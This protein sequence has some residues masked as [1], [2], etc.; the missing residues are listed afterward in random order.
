MRAVYLVASI[1][2]NGDSKPC[3]A[4]F[5]DDIRFGQKS[6]RSYR[7]EKSCD[8]QIVFRQYALD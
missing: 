2:A 6:R 3:R 5:R 4:K 7:K 1:N 8:E